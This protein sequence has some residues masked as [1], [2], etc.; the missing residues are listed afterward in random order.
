ME[1]R[2]LILL[3]DAMQRIG[4]SQ[5]FLSYNFKG[6]SLRLSRNLGGHA[7]PCFVPTEVLGQS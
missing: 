7:A 4:R 3:I 5:F 1:N 6:A 2:A